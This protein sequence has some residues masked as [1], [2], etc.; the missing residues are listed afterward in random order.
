MLF[1]FTAETLHCFFVCLACITGIIE[2]SKLFF[3]GPREERDARAKRKTSVW[4]ARRGWK[5]DALGQ[6]IVQA[7]LPTNLDRR[8]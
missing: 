8:K 1:F 3:S 4:S 7:L 6:S 2:P 5:N